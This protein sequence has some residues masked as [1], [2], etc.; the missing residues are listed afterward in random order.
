LAVVRQSCVA[1]CDVRVVAATVAAVVPVAVVPLA[2]LPP[3][4]LAAASPARPIAIAAAP[5]V[6]RYGSTVDSLKATA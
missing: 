1:V 6:R 4:P 2:E 5:L 3:Q